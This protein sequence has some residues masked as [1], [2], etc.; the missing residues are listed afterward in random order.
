MEGWKCA[1]ETETIAEL[2]LR[3]I[4]RTTGQE[5][6]QAGRSRVRDA[7]VHKLSTL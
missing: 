1:T 2:E 6:G 5:A 3:D 7:E 4:G